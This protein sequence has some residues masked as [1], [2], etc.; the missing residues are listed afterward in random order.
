MSY[1]KYIKLKIFRLGT[2]IMLMPWEFLLF[3]HF[4]D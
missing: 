2:P 3:F 1:L 4:M